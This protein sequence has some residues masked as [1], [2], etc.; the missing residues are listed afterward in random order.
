MSRRLFRLTVLGL[1]AGAVALVPRGASAQRP[2]YTVAE[3]TLDVD[4]AGVNCATTAGRC[5]RLHWVN[6]TAAAPA[7]TDT[8]PANGRPDYIDQLADVVSEVY[9]REIAS[10]GW[11]AP[12]SDAS[13]ATN[14]GSGRVDVYVTTVGCNSIAFVQ[15]EGAVAPGSNS[16]FSFVAV[17]RDLRGCY[18]SA[19]INSGPGNLA[20]MSQLEV[21]RDVFAHEFHHVVQNAIRR[22]ARSG[23]KE[24]TANWMNDEAYDDLNVNVRSS[25]LGD[26]TLFTSP[27]TALDSTV[28]GGWFWLRYLSE[29]FGAGVVRAIWDQLAGATA[30]DLVATA[31]VL[32]ANGSSLRDAFVDFAGKLYAKEW[33]E[34][35]TTYPDI[36]AA[37]IA[38]VHAAYPVTTQPVTLNHMSRR[39][40]RF[41]PQAASTQ[42]LMRLFVNG[43]DGQDSG[44]VVDLDM[45]D[46]RR[47]DARVGL[48]A[49]N[50]GSQVVSGFGSAPPPSAT[51]ARAGSA[52]LGLVNATQAANGLAFS[53]CGPDCTMI[54]G[55]DAMITPW[56]A[57]WGN[58]EPLWQTVDVWVD[59]DG[60]CQPDVAGRPGCNEPDDPG[61]AAV[62]AEPTRGRSN[63]LFARV[64]NLGDT[65]ITGAT[66]A[67]E[68][69]PFGIALPP[70][71]ASIGSASVSLAAAGSPGDQQVVSVTWD[72]SDLTF[73]NGGLWD[74]PSTPAVETTADFDHF[75]VRVQTTAAG[76]VN[77]SNN[78]A[79]NNFGDIPVG[80]S[81]RTAR[82]L[83]G[84][85][86][87][88]DVMARIVVSPPLP[89]PWSVKLVGVEVGRP[90]R[91]KKGEIRLGEAT[92]VGPKK[93]GKLT[94]DV[95]VDLSLVVDGERVS[96]LSIR[97][98]RAYGGGKPGAVAGTHPAR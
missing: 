46:G 35:G 67:F 83:V 79:Q 93:H 68:Y 40:V 12:P 81:P 61:T 6:T 73:N 30:D 21:I 24:A 27:S 28:Y 60:D 53:Y 58:R 88:R 51:F 80:G 72:L 5:F 10:M 16:W 74:V 38:P 57:A 23:F 98:A 90:F 96:G 15:S 37:A 13:S 17:D 49:N 4:P 95:V 75:C 48:D 44:A 7:Q 3:Q 47:V 84:N 14:G 22:N 2:T 25:A 91:M 66:V 20:T 26:F 87:D 77:L 42:R 86:F 82:F 71:F 85:P 34:E 70:I 31:T 59:N 92:L 78:S 94:R 36:S 19:G 55:P 32:G 97:L 64:R 39:Y 54:G 52:V 33:F 9:A 56:G 76:D 11:T 18:T 1:S 41:N 43:P 62:D 8:T 29:R 89:R 69:A 45:A 63:T 50:D 65:P